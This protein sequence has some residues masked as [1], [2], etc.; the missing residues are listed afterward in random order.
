MTEKIGIVRSAAY[1]MQSA[2]AIAIASI[3]S[4]IGQLNEINWI[5][6]T[7]GVSALSLA[8]ITSYQKLRET[9]RAQDRLDS[10]QRV[11]EAENNARLSEREAQLWKERYLNLQKTT[12]DLPSGDSPSVEPEESKPASS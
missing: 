2:L 7:G 11:T 6:L 1:E 10:L 9:R 4:I 5:A 12:Q 3:A 8:L